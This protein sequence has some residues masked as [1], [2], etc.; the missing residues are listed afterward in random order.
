[1]ELRMDQ[2]T[3]HWMKD[4]MMERQL[5]EQLMELLMDR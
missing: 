3:E 2:R 5:K 1:M 4:L